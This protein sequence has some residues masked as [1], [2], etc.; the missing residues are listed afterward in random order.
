MPQLFFLLLKWKGILYFLEVL[1]DCPW[2]AFIH[3]NTACFLVITLFRFENSTLEKKCLV[4]RAKRLLKSF[5]P[6]IADCC[7]SGWVQVSL[8]VEAYLEAILKNYC[9]SCKRLLPC[10]DAETDT[11]GDVHRSWS[12][13]RA[14]R[15]TETDP[16]LQDERGTDPSM[17]RERSG[18]GKNRAPASEI[19]TKERYT[20]LLFS[21]NALGE[22]LQACF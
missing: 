22:Q 15:R 14:Q 13:G 17:E 19:Q 16:V 2:L 18:N 9:H 20:W 1:Q 11:V 6:F 3:F 12:A 4:W 8:C 7:K 5:S 21:M 10:K